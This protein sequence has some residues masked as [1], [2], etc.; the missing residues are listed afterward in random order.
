MTTARLS[1]MR[2]PGPKT[3]PRESVRL[4]LYTLDFL[5][6]LRIVHVDGC[7]IKLTPLEYAFFRALLARPYMLVSDRQLCHAINQTAQCGDIIQHIDNLRRKL[8]QSGIDG[9]TILRVRTCGYLAFLESAP[10]ENDQTMPSGTTEVRP[11]A[12]VP[13]R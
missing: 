13:E 4:G 3:S 5:D 10:E 1:T 9:I 2:R 6:D 11:R 8:R 12:F 7:P